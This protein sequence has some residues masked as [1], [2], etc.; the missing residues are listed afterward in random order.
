LATASPK[1]NAKAVPPEQLRRSIAESLEQA[2]ARTLELVDPLSE[3]AL[4]EVHDPLMSPIVWD[5]GHIANFEELWLVRTVGSRPPLHEE[6]GSVYDPFTATRSKRGELPYLRSEDCLAYM[7]AVRERTLE[8]LEGADFS[9]RD[10]LLANGFVYELILRHER[11]HSETILQTLQIMS[12]ESYSPSRPDVRARAGDER[13]GMVAVEGGTFQMGADGG[14]FCYDNEQQLHAVELAPFWID[15]FPVSN[16]DYLEFIDDGGYSRSEWWSDEGWQWRCE[17]RA[18][19]PRYW[20]RD[21]D[22]FAERSFDRIEPLDPLR[23]VCHVSWYEADAFARSRGKRL[24]TEAEWEKA[25]TWDERAGTKRLQAW[26]DGGHDERLANLG[27]LSFGTV[28]TGAFP[29]GAA[30]C[31]AEQMMGDVWE[32]TSSGFDAYPGFEPF[33]YAE[34]SE[35][36]FGGQYRTLRGG[37]WATQPDAVTASFRNWDHPE[38]RQLFAGFR[39]VS[40]AGRDGVAV[41]FTGT[42]EEAGGD[43]RIDVHLRDGAPVTIEDDVR[44]GLSNKP[45]QLSPK[46]FYDERGSQLFERIT[47]LPEYYPTRAEQAILDRVGAEIVAASGPQELVELGP[48]SARKTHALLEPMLARGGAATYVPVDVSEAAVHELAE[49]LAGSYEGLRIHG[50]VGDFEQEMERLKPNGR[51]RLVA[52]LGGTLGNLDRDQ[53]LAFLRRC[54]RML[55]PEDRLLIGTDLVKDPARLEA[56]YNDS[57]GVTAEFN[58]NVLHVINESL[59]GDLDPELFEHVAFYDEQ[60]QRIEMRLSA[61]EAHTAQISKL[62][63]EVEFERGEEIRTEISCKFTKRVMSREYAAAGLRMLAWHTD[64]EGL[65]ALSLAGPA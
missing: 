60:A 61:R 49:R 24:P 22:G 7:S 27:Q 15:R 50:V 23:P 37:A 64:A 44:A 33:P 4:N 36:F 28:Q 8:C 32:W 65:F 51:R 35:V 41:A 16:G 3:R 18:F 17:R 55:G 38:R 13:P 57:A 43:I 10:R 34:Y 2:R 29:A 14:S 9:G 6:L 20:E 62:A 31:G 21:G 1:L 40:D 12:S 5:L 63:M 11:Q 25:A 52:F 19:A 30:P 48:G 58:R 26:G 45:K 59:D 42:A 56:A 39:C 53:R 54:R 47:R 46:Y